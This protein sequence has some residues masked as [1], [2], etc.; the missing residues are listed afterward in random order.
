M[1]AVGLVSETEPGGVV[2]SRERLGGRGGGGG[3]AIGLARI[4]TAGGD[5]LILVRVV[6]DLVSVVGRLGTLFGEPARLAAG[7]ELSVLNSTKPAG[8]ASDSAVLDLGGALGL[9]RL[10][11]IGVAFDLGAACRVLDAG[12]PMGV[13]GGVLGGGGGRGGGG[14]GAFSSDILVCGCSDAVCKLN[15]INIRQ[16]RTYF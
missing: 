2:E 14:R 13:G 16:S 3:G 15:K 7:A 9:A 11:R 6:L 5:S 1:K 12:R 10:A 8:A 4:T